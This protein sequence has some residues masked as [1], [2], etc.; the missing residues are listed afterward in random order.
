MAVDAVFLNEDRHMHNIAL[1]EEGDEYTAAPIFDNG[2]GLLSD[3]T[4][5]Y[6]AGGDIF[7]LIGKC[8]AKTFSDDFSKQLEAAEKLCGKG[9]RF[10]FG[11]REIQDLLEKEPFYPAETKQRVEAILLE[12][13][14][15][16]AYM[17]D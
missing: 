6:P 15:R 3:T 5:D 4:L 12:Q 13:K 10:H 7:R 2:A 16:Y 8:R 14:R 9:P 11:H 1:I 17:F